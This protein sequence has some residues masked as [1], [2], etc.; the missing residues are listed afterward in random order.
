MTHGREEAEKMLHRTGGANVT[1]GLTWPNTPA[2]EVI[3]RQQVPLVAALR[4]RDEARAYLR[5][6]GDDLLQL[7]GELKYVQHALTEQVTKLTVEIKRM[8]ALC[9]S[10]WVLRENAEF[11][12]Q[13]TASYAWH[14]LRQKEVQSREVMLANVNLIKKLHEMRDVEVQPELQRLSAELKES[15]SKRQVL[16]QIKAVLDDQ[17]VRN[18]KAAEVVKEARDLGEKLTKWHTTFGDIATLHDE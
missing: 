13:A 15:E 7:R 10:M 4:D 6:R 12:Q 16:A 3:A 1:A 18:R 17:N 9:E 2:D 8:S 11:L 14:D 5:E